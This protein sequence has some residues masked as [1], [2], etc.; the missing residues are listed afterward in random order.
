VLVLALEEC[1]I[2]HSLTLAG[3]IVDTA[4]PPA[5]GQSRVLLGVHKSRRIRYGKRG[6][7]RPQHYRLRPVLPSCGSHLQDRSGNALPGAV[8]RMPRHLMIRQYIHATRSPTYSPTAGCRRSA[9]KTPGPRRRKQ[10]ISSPERLQVSLL[11]VQGKRHTA[12]RVQCSPSA[13]VSGNKSA[14]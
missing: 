2:L 11:S 14:P 4:C 12:L 1:R 3:S 7:G 8:L 6:P 5:S 10:D 9:C 13:S